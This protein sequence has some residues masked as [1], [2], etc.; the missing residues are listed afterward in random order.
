MIIM[1]NSAIMSTYRNV[2][3]LTHILGYIAHSRPF[4]PIQ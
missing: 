1:S 3:K 4:S 2:D